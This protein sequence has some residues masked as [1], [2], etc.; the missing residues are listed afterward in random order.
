MDI[1]QLAELHL[2]TGYV[3][4]NGS[5]FY[6]KLGDERAE[7]LLRALQAEGFRIVADRDVTSPTIFNRPLA[8]VCV[9]RAPPNR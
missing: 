7:A 9:K 2:H 4:E 6:E 8:A 5:P 3:F 1:H